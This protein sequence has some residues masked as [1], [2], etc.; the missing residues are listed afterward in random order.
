MSG[1][2]AL[3]GICLAVV[4]GVGA[5]AYVLFERHF[6]PRAPVAERT[7]PPLDFGRG[8]GLS[9]TFVDTGG[10]LQ[11]VDARDDIPDDAREFV[12]VSGTSV[13][14]TERT[15]SLVYVADLRV[16]AADGGFP[17]KVMT[18]AQFLELVL[19]QSSER[20]LY[21]KYEPEPAPPPPPRVARPRGKGARAKEPQPVL[22]RGPGGAAGDSTG[23]AA[24]SSP[25]AASA[26]LGGKSVVLYTTAWCP[27]C[28]QAR[29]WFRQRGIPFVEH[30]I[31]KDQQAD[32]EYAQKC[33]RIGQAPGRVP[34]VEIG[35][36]LM[37][38]FA[39]GR[40]ES[41]LRR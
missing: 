29:S 41:L 8:R 14:R 31:E 40:V 16:Q 25:G 21:V 22:V 11:T 36:R 23:S 18:D 4:V 7:L 19:P 27:A 35:G 26:R 34:G 6:K 32:R 2:S 17:Y 12:K 28:T 5:G 9:Y 39:P 3:I 10:A 30:D 37:I 20:T 24:G 1:K 38:G 15:A 13:R 33:A